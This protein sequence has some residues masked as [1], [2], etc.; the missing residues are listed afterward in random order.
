MQAGDLLTP[1]SPA[2]D[3]RRRRINW[4]AII[5]LA[6]LIGLALAASASANKAQSQD[7]PGW[8]ALGGAYALHV[9]GLMCAGQAWIAL[10]PPSADRRALAGGLY[11]SQLTKYLPAGGF[12]QQASQLALSSQ[13]GVGSA[14]L[15]LP[16]FALCGVAAGATGGSLLAFDSDLPVWGR[17][18][19]ACGLTVVIA[20]DRR[21]L[22]QVLL[23]ARRFVK[24][25]PEP[26]T[27]PA[28]SAILRSYVFLLLD[29]AVFAAAFVILVADLADGVNPVLTGAALSA[30]WVLGYV[31]VIFPSGLGVREGVL[32]AV[33]SVPNN[34]LLAASVAHRLLGLAAEGTMAGLAHLRTAVAARR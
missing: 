34:A 10:F 33:L 21:I 28:Q 17:V 32:L 5:G 22:Q 16:V 26:D 12:V 19:A 13:D 4:K 18:L 20:L 14:A 1:E 3:K 6:G 15:R 27:L 7:L 2:P 31:A 11:V 30:G 24:R 29:I 23:L 9:V 8:G 25:L